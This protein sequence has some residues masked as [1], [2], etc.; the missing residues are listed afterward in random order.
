MSQAA[1]LQMIDALEAVSTPYMLVGSFSSNLYG[2][3]RSTQDADF[4]VEF[5]NTSLKELASRLGPE[6]QVDSQMSFE[7]VTGTRRFVV[8]LRDTPFKIELF[9]LSDDAHDR[10]R[11]GRRLQLDWHGRRV[12]V[13][14]AED[15][16]ITKLRWSMHG[17]RTKDVDDV[18]SVITLQSHVL[19]WDYIHRWCQVHGTMDLLSQIRATIPPLNL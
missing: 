6:F 3:P 16:V 12:W 1:V 19:D 4:V 11:F 13:P 5:G 15:V 14:T 8:S 18:R 17:R 2:I 10:E 7:T 9:L